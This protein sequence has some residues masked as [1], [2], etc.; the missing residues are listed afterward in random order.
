MCVAA[1]LIANT[2]NLGADLGAI[3]AGGSI[4]SR[5]V[6]PALWLVLPVAALIL[7][8]QFFVTYRRIFNTFKWL[9]LA[10]FA[11]VF[12]AFLAHPSLRM[13][14]AAT[15]VPHLEPSR[16]FVTALVA[17]LGTTISPYLFFW[18]ASA[19]VDEMR[20]RGHHREA[21]RRGVKLSELRAARA[22]VLIGMGFSQVVMY[23]VILTNAAVLHAHGRTDV[24]TA[25]QAAQALQPL[26]GPFAFFAFALGLIGTGFLAV[27]ILSGSAAY[28][29]KEFLGLK[30]DLSSKPAYRPTFYGVIG[31]A[32]VAGAILNFLHVDPIRALFYAAVINGLVA[33]P[34]MLQ[35]VMLG[36]DRR[37]MA[38]RASG[39][40]S[41][42]LTW[43]ATAGMSAAALTLI[44]SLIAG[45]RG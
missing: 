14:V 36:G 13:V 20:M 24:Q 39:W 37:F 42:V 10:L 40:L 21:D 45:L 8:L 30:G 44:V 4:L 35:I 38:R 33:P 6:V 5:G 41:K 12:T 27:P 3:A 11:Y 22:D 18:Q 2:I 43:I 19:E 16:D 31:A 9:T 23:A 28:A 32:T 29:F 7:Y 15:F 25:D 26:L 34:L 1:L 17:V